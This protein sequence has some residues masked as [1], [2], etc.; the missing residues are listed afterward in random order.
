MSATLATV[1]A[2]IRE[3]YDHHY[4]R[5]KWNAMASTTRTALARFA[6]EQ[7]RRGMKRALVHT[8]ADKRELYIDSAAILEAIGEVPVSE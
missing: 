6:I 8:T 2:M 5:P 4:G 7:A 1:E 3:V